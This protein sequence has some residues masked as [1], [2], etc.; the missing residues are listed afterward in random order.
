MSANRFCRLSSVWSFVDFSEI[1]SLHFTELFSLRDPIS[2]W[3]DFGMKIT[4]PTI[5]SILQNRNR[6]LEMDQNTV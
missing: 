1:L 4:V 2:V 5:L 6:I 3:H